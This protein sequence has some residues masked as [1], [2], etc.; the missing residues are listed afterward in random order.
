MDFLTDSFVVC[1]CAVVLVE[2]RPCSKAFSP[3]SAV[4]VSPE[5]ANISKFQ[6]DQETVNEKCGCITE[7]PV[8]Y[9]DLF[10]IC[11]KLCP[12]EKLIANHML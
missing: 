4:L 3:G 12:V 10:F 2:T 6:F 11:F 1:F 5:K 8:T 9:Y 7:I